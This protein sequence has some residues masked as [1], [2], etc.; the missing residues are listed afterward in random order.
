[1]RNFIQI[2]TTDVLPLLLQLDAHPELWDQHTSRTDYKESPHVGV[3]DIW[4]RW[5]R[6]EHLT[7]RQAYND[8]IAEFQWYPAMVELP[9]A[10]K[11][12]MDIMQRVGGL[13]LGGVFITRIPSGGSV[14]PHSDKIGWHARYYH[15]K[16]YVS[17]KSNP[18]CINYC[19]AADETQPMEP[20]IMAP[21]SVWTFDNCQ[22]HS[23]VNEGAE[24]RITMM[25]AI[26]CD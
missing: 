24:D 6:P 25:C 22:I 14:K 16:V 19:G 7:S 10:R 23:V 21:G 20:L 9:A 5:A 11:I 4:L 15:R 26:R 8:P 18:N 13:A 17:L 1:M 2:G 3:P 12:I